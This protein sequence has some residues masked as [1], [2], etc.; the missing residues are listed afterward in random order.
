MY[1]TGAELVRYGLEQ[2][3]IAH[4]FATVSDYNHE[5]YHQLS[6]ST[7]LRT[8]KV[9]HQLSATFMADALSRTSYHGKTGVILTTTDKIV[10][11][12]IAEAYISGIPLLVIA[13][14]N[15]NNSINGIDPQLLLKP[16]TKACFRVTQLED[17][18]NTVF[19]A[20]TI[21]TSNKPGPVVIEI[22]TALQSQADKLSQ[23]LP[24]YPQC[25]DN[26][27]MDQPQ[28]I[29]I[30]TILNAETPCILVG[31]GAIDAHS[32]IIAVAETVAAPVCSVL[33]GNSAFAAE[34]PLH[35][36]LMHAP[37]AKRVLKHC[38]C[39]L[40]IGADSAT[41]DKSEL[42]KPLFHVTLATLA[43]LVDQ[44]KV[45]QL[46]PRDNQPIVKAIAKNKRQLR[47][48]WLEHNS[49]GRVNPIVFFDALANSLQ[50]DATIVTG[51]GVHRG[52]T[53]EL[54]PINRPRGF[55]S[56]SSAGASG[57]CVPAVNAIKLANPHK[58]VI[59]IVSDDAMIINAME[60]VVAVREKLGAIYCLLNS[61]HQHA[62]NE[63]SPVNWGAFADAM[64]CGYFP[65]EDNHNI[66][67]IIRRAFETAAQGQPVIL[68]IHID[69]SRN[70]YYTEYQ[71]EKTQLM[72]SAGENTLSLVKRAIARKIS[73]KET[74]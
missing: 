18:V 19:D 15:S 45:L 32:D 61:S 12:G 62:D 53:A 23:P 10:V 67:I 51:Y 55:I 72:I 52:L 4:C 37:A 42:P 50:D 1:K 22:S 59:G 16:V 44:L 28:D 63:S 56:P 27:A 43:N 57:Y 36:G 20:Q 46:E 74:H 64:D 5:L 60:V 54:L 11:E 71:R 29:S 69:S 21:A 48:D 3:N 34:H 17:I 8:H 31:W 66:D 73:G 13:G 41:L 47:Q 25:A 6:L 26:A 40:V 49:K 30:D 35:A 7:S 58:Q 9:N 70:S 24:E 2:L 38:D 68:D 14:S 39:L 33:A 65:I